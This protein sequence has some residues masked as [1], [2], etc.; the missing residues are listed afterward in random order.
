MFLYR[1]EILLYNKNYFDEFK[2][3]FF[4]YFKGKE[5][6][7]VFYYNMSCNLIFGMYII[8]CFLFI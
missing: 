2:C 3:S 8:I 7:D 5:I 1:K 4:V 6:V